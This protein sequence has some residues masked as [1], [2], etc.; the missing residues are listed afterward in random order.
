MYDFK[1]N[2]TETQVLEADRR[3]LMSACSFSPLEPAVL[4]RSP[5][6]GRAPPGWTDCWPGHFGLGPWFLAGR[7]PP[8]D[9]RDEA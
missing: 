1:K 7:H 6:S 9:G 3:G 2:K 8:E 5:V 4:G